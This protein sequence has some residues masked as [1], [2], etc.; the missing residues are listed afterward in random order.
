MSQRRVKR[1]GLQD[2]NIYN[3]SQSEIRADKAFD[4]WQS[5]LFLNSLSMLVIAKFKG[6]VFDDWVCMDC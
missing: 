6:L 2:A 4:F 5:C 3:D 1:W